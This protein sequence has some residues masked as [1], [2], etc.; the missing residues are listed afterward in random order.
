MMRAR[1][2]VRVAAGVL[3]MATTGMAM[4]PA[5]AAPSERNV[6]CLSDNIYYE[7]RDDGPPGWGAVGHVTLN[8]LHD[9]QRAGRRASVCSIVY[10]GSNRG[11]HRCQFSWTC[12]RRT[13]AKSEAE[14]ARAITRFAR[15]LLS[16]EHTDQTA[17]AIYFHERGRHPK[18]ASDG[19]TRMTVAIGRHYYYRTAHETEVASVK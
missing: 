8:R 5:Q 18:W 14:T 9:A 15:E 6:K 12:D 11:R 19:S 4:S 7:A 16:G 2:K 13:K 10:E 1:F 17:G 3:M